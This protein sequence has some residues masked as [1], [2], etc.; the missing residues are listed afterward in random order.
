MLK[1]KDLGRTPVQIARSPPESFTR[2]CPATVDVS[3]VT[4]GLMP[5]LLRE[6]LRQDNVASRSFGTQRFPSEAPWQ[7]L[8]QPIFGIM[9]KTCSVVVRVRPTGESAS[10]HVQTV[11]GSEVLFSNHVC[12][13]KPR[14]ARFQGQH[15]LAFLQGS[16]I[17][18]RKGSDDDEL[19]QVI[20]AWRPQACICRKNICISIC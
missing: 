13:F 14:I 18:I 19:F 17:F 15:R 1:T 9:Q 12:I 3:N 16:T 8:K 11:N 4:E 5:I 7:S 2:R 20:F 10:D 6:S